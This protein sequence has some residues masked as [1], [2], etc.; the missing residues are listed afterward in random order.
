M[1]QFSKLRKSQI[2][3]KA[4]PQAPAWDPCNISHYF[5]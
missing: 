4:D 2:T 1:I 5:S 3:M